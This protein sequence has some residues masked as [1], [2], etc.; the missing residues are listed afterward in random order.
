MLIDIIFVFFLASAFIRLFYSLLFFTRN[1]VPEQPATK[2]AQSVPVSVIVCAHNE[3]EN[4]KELLPALYV[5]NHNDFEIIV[6]DDR[7][8]DGTGDWLRQE[9]PKSRGRLRSVRV[10]ETPSHI[11]HKKFAVTMAVKAAR[12]ERML[13][14]DA[15]CRPASENWVAGMAS[16]FDKGVDFVIGYCQ[17]QRRRGLL[18]ALIRFETMM[19]GL[20]YLGF[21]R[22]GNPYMAVGRNMA[23]RKS[24]F[25]ANN[26][27]GKLQGIT[28]GDDDLLVNKL[29]NRKNA[30]V[31]TGKDVAVLSVP[32][33]TWRGFGRQKTRHLSVGKYYKTTDRIALG[34]FYLSII[35]F[36][37]SFITLLSATHELYWVAGGYSVV[38]LVT[39]AVWGMAAKRM[40]D[41]FRVWKIPVLDFL[42][43]VYYILIG[44]RAFFSKKVQ[45][46]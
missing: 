46:S 1:T 35:I 7:S 19:S 9:I 42:F 4:L 11:D 25:L 16:K 34:I 17:Y 24:V 41:D 12:H 13:F 28:G 23:Y 5:Q 21:A 8:T 43:P 32:K 37:S 22:A 6:A 29:A 27:F 33:T 14:T 39:T 2:E 31:A 18:N 45:W 15:D 40:P 26:G 38:M 44:L 36:W 3:L 30:R 10:D 20:L